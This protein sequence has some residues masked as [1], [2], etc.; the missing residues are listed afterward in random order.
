MTRTFKL[1]RGISVSL[2]MY[3]IE[4]EQVIDTIICRPLEGEPDKVEMEARRSLLKRATGE[5][6]ARLSPADLDGLDVS[7][8]LRD[9]YSHAL[10]G[11]RRGLP[12]LESE[13]A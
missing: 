4:T 9:A 10:A 5:G 6:G 3:A 7:G 13:L 2:K 8:G 1:D 11:A 12:S